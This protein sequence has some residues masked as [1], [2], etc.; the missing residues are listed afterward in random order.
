VAEISPL[1]QFCPNS[2]MEHL[3]GN[4]SIGKANHQLQV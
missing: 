1:Q 2:T 3:L 4:K